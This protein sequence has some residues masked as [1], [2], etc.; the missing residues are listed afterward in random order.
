MKSKDGSTMAKIKK[1]EQVKFQEPNYYRREEGLNVVGF[2]LK[3][4]DEI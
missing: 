2:Y 1:L 3:Q 4:G